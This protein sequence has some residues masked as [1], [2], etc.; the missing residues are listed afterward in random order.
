LKGLNTQR[1]FYVEKLNYLAKFVMIQICVMNLRNVFT[2]I[3][4]TLNVKEV[5][6][7]KN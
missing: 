4:H 3:T 1:S 6:Y 2:N 5:D 7:V